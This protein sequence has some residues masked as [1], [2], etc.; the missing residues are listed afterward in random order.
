LLV[1]KRLVAS[2][3][4]MVTDEIIGFSGDAPRSWKPRVGLLTQFNPSFATKSVI[5]STKQSLEFGTQDAKTIWTMT[6]PAGFSFLT[7]TVSLIQIGFNRAGVQPAISYKTLSV[8][9]RN[10]RGVALK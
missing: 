6:T 9:V 5:G 8:S 7:S 10:A 3:I 2:T 1:E 4:R